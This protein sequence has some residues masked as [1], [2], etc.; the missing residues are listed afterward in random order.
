MSL[1]RKVIDMTNAPRS[2]SVTQE[3]LTKGA[4]DQ[5]LEAALRLFTVQGFDATPTA[6]ISKEAGVSTGTLFHYFST[7]R[8]LLEELYLSIKK[9]MSETLQRND[10]PKLPTKQ[11]LFIALRSYIEWALANP[12]E[13]AFLDQL[14][15]SANIG[16]KVKQEG[17]DKFNWMADI[18]K[19]AI[20]EGILN[21][22]PLEFHLVMIGAICTGIINL[23]G[24]TNMT[25]DMLVKAGLAM[26]IKK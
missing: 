7:K 14:Y 12:K 15:H 4:R 9:G 22:N 10:D 11:R 18:V 1:G 17:Y 5:I 23:Q 20:K 19:A 26:L 13:Y 8:E 2:S 3:G 6:L 24:R 21:E 25:I 16:Q